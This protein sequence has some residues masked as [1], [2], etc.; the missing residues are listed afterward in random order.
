M[1]NDELTENS[2]LR[3][4][5]LELVVEKLIV[6]MVDGDNAIKNRD[7]INL[8]QNFVKTLTIIDPHIWANRV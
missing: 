8:C 1:I 6:R 7:F 4:S 3:K 2:E 5:N